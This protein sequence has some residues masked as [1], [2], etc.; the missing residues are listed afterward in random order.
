[1]MRRREPHRARL[2]IVVVALVGRLDR[3]GLQLRLVEQ[4]ARELRAGAGKIRALRP[5]ARE[6]A[7]DP[8]LRGEQ[9]RQEGKA[10]DGEQDGHRK[11]YLISAATPFVQLQ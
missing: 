3:H 5:V 4:V 9:Q 6:H 1:M 10:E 2:G 8:E 7:L 11:L